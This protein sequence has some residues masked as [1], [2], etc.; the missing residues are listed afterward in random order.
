MQLMHM[1]KLIKRAL[2]SASV[3]LTF[4]IGSRSYAGTFIVS[5]DANIVNPLVASSNQLINP[6]NVQ[7]FTN[8]LEGGTNVIVQSTSSGDDTAV[9][10]IESEINSFYNSL[11]GVTSTIVNDLI[12]P[13]V[14]SSADL[15]ISS[16][17]DDSFTDA[18]IA[19]LGDFLENNGSIFFVGD[20][21]NFQQEN[22]RIN[23]ALTSLGSSINILDTDIFDSGFNTATGSRIV[24]NP[25]T[26]GVNAFTYAGASEVVGGTSLFLG[27]TRQTFLS[28]E[29]T[30]QVP[31]PSAI[32]G[33]LAIG[34]IGWLMKRKLKT[35]KKA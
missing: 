17:P 19:S 22:A 5:G 16:L 20:N 30:T 14:L 18:E 9:E 8:I 33:V 3:I 23:A 1:Y 27:L 6:G 10:A 32:G 34:S 24:S 21:N 26:A 13:A 15:F 4:S 12:T 7:F 28:V 29:N 11:T 2:C 25:L 35:S 31:E